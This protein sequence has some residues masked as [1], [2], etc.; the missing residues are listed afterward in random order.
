[1]KHS[2]RIVN[3]YEEKVSNKQDYLV[4]NQFGCEMLAP[5][6]IIID[7][8]VAFRP[9]DMEDKEQ[10]EA[11]MTNTTFGS[12]SQ[13]KSLNAFFQRLPKYMSGANISVIAVN[14]VRP[15][16][17]DRPSPKAELHMRTG[18]T[19]PGGHGQTQLADLQ[20]TMRSTEKLKEDKAYKMFGH[21]NQVTIV[22]SRNDIAG[23]MYYL[24]F[25]PDIGFDDFHSS[26]YF[27]QNEKMLK[28]SPHGYYLEHDGKKSIKFTLGSAKKKYDENEEFHDIFKAVVED[29]LYGKR[30][31]N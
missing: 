1:M 7:T 4:E 22:K 24:I 14:H 18:D 10:E 2:A 27:L 15:L 5:T 8:V 9:A 19:I 6:F 23:R 29:C 3:I 25:N 11:D 12:F 13:A 21:I 17:S 26:L 20:I 28:G 30:F 16:V 31:G